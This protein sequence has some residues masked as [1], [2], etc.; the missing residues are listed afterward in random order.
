MR[1]NSSCKP[2]IRELPQ[3]ARQSEASGELT[4]ELLAES[5]YQ[6]IGDNDRVGTDGEPTVKGERHNCASESVTWRDGSGH[7]TE[8]Y[9]VNDNFASL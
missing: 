8:W 1:R 9:R 4:L 6:S 7:E 5:D 3:G 2:E